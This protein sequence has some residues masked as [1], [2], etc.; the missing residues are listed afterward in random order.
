MKGDIR[1]CKVNCDN[2]VKSPAEFEKA[3]N[4]HF[5]DSKDFGL[6]DFELPW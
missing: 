3:S 4:S 6:S 1:C 5:D 2:E